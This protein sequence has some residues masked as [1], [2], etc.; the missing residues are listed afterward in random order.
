M[1]PVFA[2]IT[3]NATV[4]YILRLSQKVSKEVNQPYTI[5]T[6]DLAV[7]KKAYNIIWQNLQEFSNVVIRLGVF[8]FICAYMGAVE[9]NLRG[10]GFEEII[11]EAGICASGSIEKVMTGKHYNRALRVHKVVLEAL[12]RLLLQYLRSNSGDELDESTWEAVMHLAKNPCKEK[13]RE[14]LENPG[15]Q[16]LLSLLTDLK[17]RIRKGELGKTPQYWLNYMDRVWLI[18]ELQRATKTNSWNLH[19]ECLQKMCP[20]FFSY[21]HQNYARY[22][23]FYFLSML[24][25]PNSHPGAE[26]LM[27]QNGFSV[28]RSDIP[29]SRNA[30]DITIEQTINRYAKSHGGIIGFSRNQ[31]AY[32]RWCTTRHARGTY[33]QATLLLADM[34]SQ[35][36]D[37]HKD[38]RSSQ[39]AKSQD[40][41]L[42]VMDAYI[43]LVT[44]L[45]VITKIHF[46]AS[47]L[48]HLYQRML[49]M[50]F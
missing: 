28:R 23:T 27:E 31:S 46:I 29:S 50:T 1:L 38:L 2:P 12:E 44:R 19:L 47:P 43:T 21:D 18:L 49:R 14:A 13:L 41:V 37:S 11:L 26:R 25:L 17:A 6:A 24:N 8:H 15:C 5:I 3:E 48:G 9:K 36:I 42:N 22:S 4:Q 20:L 30:V 35:E 10:S 45:I 16:K 34:D 7:A 33:H 32:Y 40:D 39:T